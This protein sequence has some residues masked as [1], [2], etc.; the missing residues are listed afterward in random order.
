MSV[1]ALEVATLGKESA[2]V[3]LTLS[4]GQIGCQANSVDSDQTAP[5][6]VKTQIRLN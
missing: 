4:L 5:R 2:I 6:T 1:V 3:K